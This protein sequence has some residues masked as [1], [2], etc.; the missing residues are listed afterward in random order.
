MDDLIIYLFIVYVI[1]Y[2]IQ[3]KISYELFKNEGF[4]FSVIDFI[5]KLNQITFSIWPIILGLKKISDKR[6]LFF[7]RIN[8]FLLI[9]ILLM[10]AILIYI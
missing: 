1:L 8:T 3:I 10:I 7:L 5:S 4:I 2:L 9:F 6:N